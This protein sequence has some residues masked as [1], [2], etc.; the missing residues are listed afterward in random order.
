MSLS[1]KRRQPGGNYYVRGTVA[2]VRVYQSTGTSR[3][4]EAEAV[5][6]RIEQDIR[7]RH[8][9]GKGPTL[10]FAEAAL[11]YME[12]GGETRFL[13]PLIAHFGPDRLL[14]EIDNAAAQ[15]AAATL[16]PGAADSTVNR[17]VITP[18]SAVYRLAVDDGR[19]P[20]RRFKRRKSPPARTRWLTPEEA[21]RLLAA[22]P[23]HLLPALGLLLGGGCR[24][25]EALALEVQDFHAPTG[26]AWIART[27][28]GH[29]R[30]IQLPARALDLIL[31][32]AMP[33]IGTICRTPKGKPYV[34]RTNGGGQIAAAFGRARAAAGL[35]PDVT[36]HVCRHTWATWY[37]AQTRDF[38]GLLDLGGWRKADMAQQYRK[39]APADLADRLLAH[40]WDFR[41]IGPKAAA[42]RAAGQAASPGPRLRRIK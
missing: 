18:L 38:G 25:G 8:A 39:I 22:A 24:A 13:G 19:A 10:T 6:A 42:A 27:K 31:A 20:P 5:A 23:D 29:P 30:M 7:Q 12:T 28:N 37:Y 4:A 35:G 15:A 36:P 17:Q 14:S 32:P 21:E 9:Y 16:Y 33:E 1:I 2:G 3:R 40:G 41:Q 34:Q 11:A 26:E